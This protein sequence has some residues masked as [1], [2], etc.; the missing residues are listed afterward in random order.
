MYTGV[1][2][3]TNGEH[4]HTH[5]CTQVNTG[6]HKVNTRIYMVNTGVCKAYMGV[7][8]EHKYTQMYMGTV[9]TCVYSC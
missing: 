6:A 7:H 5:K 1:H 9:Y 4:G 3:C 2:R 8:G